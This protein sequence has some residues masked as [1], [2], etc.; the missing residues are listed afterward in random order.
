MAEYDVKVIKKQYY[1]YGL[2]T[3]MQ[4]KKKKQLRITTGMM[5]FFFS[6]TLSDFSRKG[7]KK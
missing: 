7:R 1:G 6:R 3:S 4:K 2:Q 5:S